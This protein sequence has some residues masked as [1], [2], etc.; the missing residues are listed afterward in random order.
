MQNLGFWLP[1]VKTPGNA[2]IFRGRVEKFKVHGDC[3]GLQV[4]I[5][6]M[7]MSLFHNN[8]SPAKSCFCEINPVLIWLFSNQSRAGWRVL[9]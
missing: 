7:V 8:V 3:I 4:N 2:D 1:I 6:V 5:F 9:R